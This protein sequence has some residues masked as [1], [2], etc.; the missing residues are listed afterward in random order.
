MATSKSS[1]DGDGT[2][3][4]RVLQAFEPDLS[5]IMARCVIRVALARLSMTLES[6]TTA[7]VPTLAAELK[8]GLRL[9]APES[10]DSCMRRLVPVLD[11]LASSN[12]ASTRVASGRPSLP[13]GPRQ[14]ATQQGVPGLTR[15]PI[16][17]ESDIL[18]AR[19]AVREMCGR[20]GFSRSEEVK[21]ATVVSEL[22]RNIVLYA[23]RGEVSLRRWVEDGRVGIEIRARDR[24]PGIANTEVILSGKYRSR[25]GLGLGILG[26][27]RLAHQFEITS[28]VGGTEVVARMVVR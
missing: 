26:T 16:E 9:Y 28:G 27:K 13:Q 3:E 14:I 17:S 8:R 10:V 24:G 2:R 21:A 18:L 6:L 11:A 12:E 5:A 23:K 7:Q 25:T 15:L 4:E 22:A 20:L 19:H 1:S